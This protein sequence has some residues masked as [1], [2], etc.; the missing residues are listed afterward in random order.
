MLYSFLI[1]LV[2]IVIWV[3][4]KP[5]SNVALFLIVWYLAFIVGVP[6]LLHRIK[7]TLGM[8]YI[9]IG[10]P[11]LKESVGFT[12][13]SKLKLGVRQSKG[14]EY[15][16]Q[17]LFILK[18]NLSKEKKSLKYLDETILAVDILYSFEQKIPYKKL[19][20]LAD[21]LAKL[22]SLNH[23]PEALS[24]FLNA[25]EIS[26]TQDFIELPSKK[27]EK[28]SSFIEKYLLPIALLI[29]TFLGIL[30]ENYKAQIIGFFEKLQW[31]Q[32]AIIFIILFLF[33][34]FLYFWDRLQLLTVEYG[35]IKEL[36]KL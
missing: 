31:M 13:L 34:E 23:I 24:K 21:E 29:V 3:I 10:V 14:L 26:W 16:L 5:E 20:V 6:I 28:V 1:T 2:W 8:N 17:S 27:H 19:S 9:K 22:P 11:S 4:L 18:E 12:E 32:L 33:Y 35:D 36:S 25:S 30:P 7:N 15:L